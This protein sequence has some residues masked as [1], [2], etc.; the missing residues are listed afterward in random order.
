M[1]RGRSIR[2]SKNL[3]IL[4]FVSCTVL[5]LL[6]SVSVGGASIS[7]WDIGLVFAH[8]LFHVP[9]PDGVD[10]IVPGL[11]WNIRLPRVFLSFV[12]GAALAVSGS[13]MQSVLKNPL[14]SSYTVG[15]SSGA[16][17]G[18]V[19]V[20]VCGISS[21]VLG[22]F[23]LPVFAVV[24]GLGTVFVSVLFASRIDRNL[25][26]FSIVLMGMVLSIFANAVMMTLASMNSRH[27][28]Q[29]VSWQL[30]SFALKG[31]VV[32]GIVSV[33]SA[34][35][36]LWLTRYAK[37]MDVLTF[38]D[39]QAGALGLE[40]KKT[41]WI[42]IMLSAVLTGV[43]VAFVGV[44]GF[45]DLIAPHIVRRFFGSLHK[46]VVPLS[47][48]FGGAFMVVADVI[49]RTA[50]SPSEIPVGSVTALIGAPFFAY[51]FLRSRQGLASHGSGV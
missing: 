32:V 21:G 5:A 9:L 19:I 38:G 45:V 33:V 4:I 22:M 30:G 35:V 37:E 6:L 27:A 44:V 3:K 46:Y 26:N 39:E 14:A 51:V 20:I 11:I 17:L 10:R 8:K 48:L 49:A 36:I 41:K 29:I 47:G 28:Q 40:V 24:F 18:A 13:V 42:L 7:L 16:G 25:D 12:V 23:L 34:V 50:V 43:A 31:W 2:L 1:S 15:V